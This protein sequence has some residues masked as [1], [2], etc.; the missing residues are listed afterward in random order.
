MEVGAVKK[1]VG[2]PKGSKTKDKK[3]V[4]F[5][6]ELLRIRHLIQELLKML[7]KFLPLTYSAPLTSE[8]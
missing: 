1:K 6:L 4:I 2:R 5:T 7:S 8:R 3:E